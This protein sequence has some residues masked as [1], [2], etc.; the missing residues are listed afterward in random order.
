MRFIWRIVRDAAWPGLVV[1][2]AHGILGK[3]LGH[4][5]YVDPLMHF[6]G[7]VAAAYFFVRL[8]TLLPDVFGEPPPVTRYLFAL[9]LTCAVALLWEF[10]EFLSDALLGTRIQ[11]SIGNTMRD[12][13]NG[14]LGALVFIATDLK[15]RRSSATET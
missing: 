3:V 1:L 10:G 7:G 15:L 12:L 6:L 13:F 4:E 8:L 5:P 11:R 9:G 2:A 14:M